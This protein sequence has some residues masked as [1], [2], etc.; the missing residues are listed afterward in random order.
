MI[1]WQIS[2]SKLANISWLKLLSN[3]SVSPMMYSAVTMALQTKTLSSAVR[4]MASPSLRKLWTFWMKP[5]V[6]KSFRSLVNVLVIDD[7]EAV[8]LEPTIDDPVDADLGR[9]AVKILLA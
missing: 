6:E 4:R 9:L 1:C 3:N 2:K 5:W 8:E 7:K